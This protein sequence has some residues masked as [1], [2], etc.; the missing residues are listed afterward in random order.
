[1]FL[2]NII[3]FILEN[4]WA[5]IVVAL[6]AAVALRLAYRFYRNGLTWTEI[7]YTI[8]RAPF[9][10]AVLFFCFFAALPFLIMF[11]HTF[12]TDSDL[13]RRPQ[14][15]IYRDEPTLEHL[16]FLFNGTDYAY[17]IR[18]SAIVG[19]AVVI[20]TLVLAI[21]AAYALARLTGRWGE[22]AGIL[23]FLV[24]LVPPTLL[25]IPMFRIIVLLGLKDNL[26]SLILIYP[27]ITVP[28]SVWLLQGFF[29]AIPRELEEAAL[30]DGYD[31]IG[32]FVRVVMPLSLPGVISTI[33]FT[34]TLTLHEFVY[35]LVFISD[36]QVRTLS[37]GVPT[38]LI[39]GDVFF[40]QPLLASA[41]LI[42]IPVG[43]V[44]NFFLDSLVQ[45]F[46]MGAVKG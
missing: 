34:F 16:E 38:E 44:Y 21:P 10:L 19:V 42:A 17:F 1:M 15:F 46:T 36:S 4:F 45:G 20:I 27:T 2:W 7:R 26:L 18:N 6:V 31:L 8:R 30:V 23:M 41:L 9:Y 5:S 33:V 40:W 43:L 35:A 28:F 37:A 25:F 3:V 32:A 11:L 22:R 13:Y 24:Y 14:P 12:K 39:L 29:K